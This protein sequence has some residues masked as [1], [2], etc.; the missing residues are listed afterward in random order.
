M[1]PPRPI[2]SL[3]GIIGRDGKMDQG[4]RQQVWA[5]REAGQTSRSAA[6]RGGPRRLRRSALAVSVFASIALHALRVLGAPTAPT[7]FQVAHLGMS[8]SAWKA[9]PPPGTLSPHT[10]PVCSDDPGANLTLT[11]VERSRG[12]VVCAYVDVWGKLSLP[13]AFTYDKVFR[14]DHLRYWFAKGRLVQIRGG[15]ALD[16]YNAVIADFTRQYGP[17]IKLVR[18]IV[19]TELGPLPRVTQTWSTPRGA[20]ELVDPTLPT[21]EIEIRLTAAKTGDPPGA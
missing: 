18:D 10:R 3:C 13:V 21:D 1:G 7:I 2:P 9:M 12:T 14:L 20:I 5:R 11:D 8:Q 6:G 17:A 19:N 4:V 16:G 15:L